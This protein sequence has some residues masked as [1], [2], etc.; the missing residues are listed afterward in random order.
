LRRKRQEDTAENRRAIEEA[1]KKDMATIKDAVEQLG[2]ELERI[3]K[4]LDDL[5][6]RLKKRQD[7]YALLAGR[8]KK[9]VEKAGLAQQLGLVDRALEI[10]LPLNVD[11]LDPVVVRMQF[12]LLLQTGRI[13]ELT[14]RFCGTDRRLK[15]TLR[16]GG[17]GQVQLATGCRVP[18]DQWYS[19]LLAA[20]LGDYAE[21]DKV[22]DG[23]LNSL[24]ARDT[25]LRTEGAVVGLYQ[26]EVLQ[27]QPLPQL[28][29]MPHPPSQWM[30]F[31]AMRKANE[32][33][34]LLTLRGLLALE[35]GNTTKAHGYFKDALPPG[36]PSEPAAVFGSQE[37]ARY[38]LD[39]VERAGR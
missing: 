21:A 19:L 2:K 9:A 29:R 24:D 35:A 11:E 33:A 16:T 30:A 31:A 18:A 22:L 38:Y 25:E 23:M 5:S 15:D 27:P 37:A 28:V 39:L 20:A 14:L 4:E 3:P 7:E 8:A 1:I 36:G 32:R 12:E 10:V 13:E 6:T 26:E 17:L 34:T